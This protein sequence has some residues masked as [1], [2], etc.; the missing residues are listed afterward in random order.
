MILFK[1]RTLHSHWGDYHQILGFKLLS[2]S[3][4]N[5]ERGSF[6]Q[7]SEVSNVANVPTKGPPLVQHM[8]SL[9]REPYLVS[10]R[11]SV[12]YA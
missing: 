12:H 3:A 10:A 4:P 1:F 11:S 2:F 6:V 5:V 8:G 9:C 7:A